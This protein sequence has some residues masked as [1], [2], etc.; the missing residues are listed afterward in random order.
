MFIRL[1]VMLS[2]ANSGV[3]V[4]QLLAGPAYEALGA[5][6]EQALRTLKNRVRRTV[7]TNHWAANSIWAEAELQTRSFPVR[8]VVVHADRRFPAGPKVDLPVRYLKLEDQRGELY[9][10]LPDFGEILYCPSADLFR[11]TLIEAVRSMTALMTPGQVRRMWPPKQTELRWLRIKLK[12]AGNGRLAAGGDG[13]LSLVAEP[14]TARQFSA[15][16]GGGREAAKSSLEDCLKRGS[17]LVVGESGAGKTVLISAVARQIEEERRRKAKAERA[18]GQPPVRTP[19][20]WSTSGGRLIAGMRYLGQWQE[21]LETVVAELAN[22]DGILA[23]DNLLELVAVGGREPRDSLAAFLIPFIR[24][25]RLRMVAEATPTELDACRRLLPAL[26]DA[27]PQVVLE[28]MS[29]EHETELVRHTLKNRFQASQATFDPDVPRLISRLCRQFQ[30]H[31][32]APGPAM[33]FVDELTSRRRSADTPSHW[34]TSLT[35]GKFSKRTGLPITLLDDAQTL[36]KSTVIDQLSREVIGQ[37][38]ACTTAA[39]VVTRIKSAVQDPGRPFAC[40]LFCGPTGV[41]KTQLAKSLT[42]FL[43]GASEG[44]QPLTRLDMSEFAGLAAGHRFLSDAEG[45]PTTWIQQ[46]R[47]RPLSVLL[48]DEIE[49][50]SSEVFDILLSLLDEGRLTDRLGRVTSFRTTVIIMTSNLGSRQ[51]TSLGFGDGQSID[52]ASEVRRSFRPEF[53]NRLDAVVPFVPLDRTAVRSITEKEL[54][55]LKKREGLERYGRDLCWTDRLLDHLAQDGFDAR[56]GARP[57]QRTIET[58]VVSPLARWLVEHGASASQRIEL[59]WDGKL[60][61]K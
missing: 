3:C 31:S 33:H 45:Q 6:A 4:A 55:D 32:A 57:L 15:H 35:L 12:D 53:F 58:V 20:V 56:L 7:K 8:P 44:K 39:G 28:P 54:N 36:A 34:T 50:A 23:V 22:L 48:L 30:R 11:S 16:L 29:V 18:R 47:T 60:V 61:V 37:T 24:G 21:R 42:Q 59:D 51:S 2:F 27:L 38:A 14:I 49:K 52:Y 10:L 5:S 9:C 46:I 19:A 40:M 1:P 41:G 13:K 43:F 26:V 25:G 17:A